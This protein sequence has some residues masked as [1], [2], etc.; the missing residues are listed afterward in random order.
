[1]G[2]IRNTYEIVIPQAL[3]DRWAGLP[4]DDH[5]RL[6][7]RLRRAARSA[8]TKPTIWPEG[9]PGIHRGLHR[10]IVDEL[11]VLYQVN[12]QAFTLSV[13]EFGIAD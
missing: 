8:F 6:T 7:K 4:W 11:W 10:A 9:P 2:S 3:A 12:D 1:M 5:R 13:Q